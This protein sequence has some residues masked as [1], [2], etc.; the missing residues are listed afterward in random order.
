[1][2]VAHELA[3]GCPGGGDTEAVYYVVETALEEEDE[4]LTL[5]ALETGSGYG[6]ALNSN[7]TMAS[8]KSFT[9]G[10]GVLTWDADRSSWKL[11]GNLYATGFVTSGGVNTQ[12]SILNVENNV[13][14]NTGNTVT[15]GAGVLSYNNGVWKLSSG[16]NVAA[17]TISTGGT[18]MNVATAIYN[19][20]QAIQ[21]H[22]QRI[23]ELEA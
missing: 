14:I 19:L 5:L 22:E 4:V 7:V 20:Q 3:G 17:L 8:A 21:N 18:T 10:D 11:A 23:S 1:M 16:L 6:I 2:I 15:F 12:D 13:V 9:L